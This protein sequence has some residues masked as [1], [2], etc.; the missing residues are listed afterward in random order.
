MFLSK[1][2]G[3]AGGLV[4]YHQKENKVQLH[5][6]SPYFTDVMFM[7]DNNVDWRFTWFYGHLA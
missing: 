5:H 3:K 7:N 2:D 6:V 1:S 4:L